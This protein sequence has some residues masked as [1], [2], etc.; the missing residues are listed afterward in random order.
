MS[1]VTPYV[2]PTIVDFTLTTALGVGNDANLDNL[3]SGI[4]GLSRCEFAEASRLDTY[5]GEIK[6]LEDVEIPESLARYSCRNNKLALLALEQDDFS[7]KVRSL[8]T[9]HGSQRVGVIIGTSTSGI[10]QTEQAYNESVASHQTA[11]AANGEKPQLTTLPDWYHYRET[12]NAH[13]VSDFVARVLGIEGYSLTIS[14]ACS[15]SAKVFA[16]GARAISAGLCDAVV[17]GGVDSLCLTTLF[18]FN[19]LQLVSREVC[20]PCDVKRNGISIGEAGGFAIIT[21]DEQ[22]GIANLVGYGESA[23]AYHMSSPH[24]DGKGA[25][26]CMQA[27]LARADI[28]PQLIGYLNLHGTGTPANDES[29]CKAV[30]DTFGAATPCSSTKGFTGHTLGACGIVESAFSLFALEH[31]FLPVNLNVIE[32]DPNIRA[33]IVTESS[34]GKFGYT[35]T[36]AFGFGGNNCSLIFGMPS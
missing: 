5:V 20:R 8:V 35:M 11:A 22:P 12:H 6:G 10:R 2:S 29:E 7:N 9:R 1:V 31:Q 16:T 27:A 18:G 4:S 34:H 15:S 32:L 14:T 21:R 33:N 26:L 13:S 3:T 17:V 23:D 36:N 25:Y 30:F 19:S 28:P 24:P